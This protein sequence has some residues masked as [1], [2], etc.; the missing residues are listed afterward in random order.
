MLAQLGSISIYFG[1]LFVIIVPCKGRHTGRRSLQEVFS[2][3]DGHNIAFQAQNN[4]FSLISQQRPARNLVV[5][6]EAVFIALVKMCPTLHTSLSTVRCQTSYFWRRFHRAN[7]V[8]S[9][10][11]IS[12]V[13]STHFYLFTSVTS[14]TGLCA[15]KGNMQQSIIVAVLFRVF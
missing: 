3:P 10:F 9:A 12:R 2:A 13:M 15:E 8:C 14:I 5:K 6:V 4:A 11:G 1:D 7:S